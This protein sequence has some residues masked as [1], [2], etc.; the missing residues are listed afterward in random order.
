MINKTQYN[1]VTVVWRGDLPSNTPDFINDVC[2]GVKPRGNYGCVVI[3]ND[4]ERYYISDHFSSYPIWFTNNDYD[5]FYH[6]L[7]KRTNN[8]ER[9]DSFFNERKMMG[10]FTVSLRTPYLNIRRVPTDAMIHVKNGETKIIKQETLIDDKLST[11]SIEDIRTY[12]ENLIEKNVAEKNV[13]FLSGGKD[14]TTL[15]HIIKKLGLE[16]K[17]KFV[18]LW[19]PKAKQHEKE[20]VTRIASQLQ[21]D[22]QFVPIEYSGQIFDEETNKHFFSHWIENT[23]SAKRKAIF[24]LD[25]LKCI[26]GQ[27]LS[28]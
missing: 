7:V 20:P 19:S 15:A 14:S 17:F 16:K 24:D 11:N 2:T 21:I 3:L 12:F 25:I 26:L 1:G 8:L 27:E 13:L 18:S 28:C 10:G 9:D 23:Y 4:N 22:V 6:D 5:W